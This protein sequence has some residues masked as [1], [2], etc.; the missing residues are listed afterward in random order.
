MANGLY[1]RFHEVTDEC[2]QTTQIKLEFSFELLE[3]RGVD[4]TFLLGIEE[5]PLVYEGILLT[6][7]D[8]FLRFAKADE[9][10]DRWPGDGDWFWAW[11]EL[12]EEWKMQV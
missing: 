3:D 1:V 2:T 8:G 6:A 5:L 9:F 4:V 11:E 12:A 7:R 10:V